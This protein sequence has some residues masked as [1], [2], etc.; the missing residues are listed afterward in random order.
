M[1]KRAKIF[2]RDNGLCQTC[3][4]N[5]L[6]TVATQV[7]HIKPLHLGGTDDDS[8]LESICDYCHK[9]KTKEEQAALDR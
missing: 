3:K 1:A 8:N 5:G 2:A 7:D 4:R 6:V 9:A